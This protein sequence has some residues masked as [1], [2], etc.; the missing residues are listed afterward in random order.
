MRR[1]LLLSAAAALALSACAPSI[2]ST[3]PAAA[4][5]PPAAWRDSS[6]AARVPVSAD[7][8]RQLGDPAIPPLVERALANNTDVLTAI[9]RVE[10]AEAAT[11]TASAASR[12]T[13]DAFGVAGAQREL[14]PVTGK[15]GNSVF[16]QP[17]L[18]GA[19]NLD[20][21]GRVRALEGA[22]RAKYVASQ[23]DRDATRLSVVS[24]TVR[25]Y[26]GLL[27]LAAQIEVSRETLESRKEALR[28]ATDRAELGYTS[29]F[30]RTQALSEY[31]S[32]AQSIPPLEQ[33][34]RVQ[35]NALRLLTG[36]M[37]GAVAQGQLRNLTLPPTPD[38]L[39]STLLRRRPDLASA[40][41]TL[42]AADSQLA[43]RRAEFLPDVKLTGSAGAVFVDVLSWNPVTL[44]DIGASVLAPIFSGGRLTASL[45]TATSQRDQAAFA[46]RG[47]AL[48]AFGEVEN[49][50]SGERRLREQVESVLQR[51]A[52]LQ[53][54]LALA[55]DRYHNGYASYLEELDAQR[56]LFQSDLAAIN[57][58]EDQLNNLVQLW[59]ALGG[60]WND[61][62][63]VSV[64]TPRPANGDIEQR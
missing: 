4:I 47:A 53:R 33:A 51:R 29:Q 31:E 39:P 49:A 10:E 11:R 15:G 32:I 38:G 55:R 20:L 43:S 58:R 37:P 42:V 41:Y 60:G 28:I 23:A 48:T 46:Y 54:S 12:P 8:W 64:P 6:Q 57:V 61:R 16:A 59:A 24:A 25:G 5:G 13:L 9:A 1:A 18:N 35:E 19:W 44:W 14:S 40:E 22:A 36:D 34:F 62:G 50:L 27:S 30:E 56:N 2:R 17:K 26:I 52:I 63:L 7:W 45:D 21:S 3:P